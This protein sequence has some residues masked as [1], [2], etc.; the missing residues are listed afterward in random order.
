MKHIIA[1]TLLLLV[2]IGCSAQSDDLTD[3]PEITDEP[4]A[5]SEATRTIEPTRPPHAT[6]APNTPYVTPTTPAT[7]P[8]A[9]MYEADFPQGLP[10]PVPDP[11][12]LHW[13]TGSQGERRLV[14]LKLMPHEAKLSP[15]GRFLAASFIR[16]SQSQAPITATMRIDLHGDQH[17]VLS[18]EKRNYAG[19]YEWMPDSRLLWIDDEGSVFLDDTEMNTPTSMTGI[20]AIVG[21]IAFLGGRDGLYRLDLTS[22]EWE[23]I[24][25]A[26]GE[27]VYLM[28]GVSEDGTYI[29][30]HGPIVSF[31]DE[32]PLYRVPVAMGTTAE[33]IMTYEVVPLGGD[34]YLGED[35]TANLAG[36]NIWVIDGPFMEWLSESSGRATES[37]MLD[38]DTQKML[39]P[40]DFGLD[41]AYII[42]KA[43]VTPD[44]RS[45]RLS[46][47]KDYRQDDH[48]FVIID[49]YYVAS[50]DDLRGGT[51]VPFTD[52]D[53]IG[54]RIVLE[55]H[56]TTPP[57]IIAEQQGATWASP[58][59]LKLF[60]LDEGGA[61]MQSIDLSAEFDSR[62][63]FNPWIALTTDDSIVYFAAV[64]SDISTGACVNEVAIIAW[65]LSP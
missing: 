10:M 33:Y 11:A 57:F 37:L 31:I 27:P 43:A 12:A 21:S 46:L 9:C 16:G 38:L 44:G 26:D 62:G 64:N 34:G 48:G 58:E 49:E 20:K 42:V 47:T 39:T 7:D 6:R 17:R 40:E 50:G 54:R 51:L 15:D 63:G 41:P 4:T 29:L 5:I 55:S 35:E 61:P 52:T 2:L 32:Y 65:T 56:V 30:T 28:R 23:A 22:G 60:Q 13:E 14:G 53:G 45:V 24:T 1:S 18:T 8:L 36:T 59:T 19:F 25:T 3:A